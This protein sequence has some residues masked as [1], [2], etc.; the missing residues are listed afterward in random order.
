MQE[1]LEAFCLHSFG[2]PCLLGIWAEL[3]YEPHQTSL[4]FCGGPS[5]GCWLPSVGPS[6]A[7]SPVDRESYSCLLSVYTSALAEVSSRLWAVKPGL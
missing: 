1:W 3:F 2:T 4:G 5:S 7:A 6:L